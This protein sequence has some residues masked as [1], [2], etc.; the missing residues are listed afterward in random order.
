MPRRHVIAPRR[1]R[2]RERTLCLRSAD[3]ALPAEGSRTI[4]AALKAAGG[5]VRYTEYPLVGHNSWEAAYNEP[6]LWRWLFQQRR[7]A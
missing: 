7:Q 5:D 3:M 6:E 1:R 2:L 4:F